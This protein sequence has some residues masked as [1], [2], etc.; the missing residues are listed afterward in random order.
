V[1]ASGSAFDL[2][3]LVYLHLPVDE[4]VPVYARAA[5]AVAPVGDC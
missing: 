2:V 4:R 5:S 1:V 3:V